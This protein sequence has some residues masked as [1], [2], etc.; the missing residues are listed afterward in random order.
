M[1]PKQSFFSLIGIF[2]FF[3]LFLISDNASAAKISCKLPSGEVIETYKSTCNS[4][5]GAE[6]AKVASAEDLGKLTS[7][8]ECPNCNLSGAVLAQSNLEGADLSGADLS[9][10]DLT[11]AN[12]TDANITRV[13]FCKTTMPDGTTN[14]SGC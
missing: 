9:N 1:K 5:E 13:K 2:L 10:I 6:V 12:L 11:G 14:N 7:T 3:T 8:N 4:K